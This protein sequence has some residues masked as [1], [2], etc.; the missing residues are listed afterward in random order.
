MKLKFLDIR[1]LIE[2]LLYLGDST[3]HRGNA[4]KPVLVIHFI[5]LVSST[6]LSPTVVQVMLNMAW[7]GTAVSLAV[8]LNS[9]VMEIMINEYSLH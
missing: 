6:A 5:L 7:S 2:K 8:R 3:A 1:E 4:K 9:E